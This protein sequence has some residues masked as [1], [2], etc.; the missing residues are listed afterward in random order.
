MIWNPGIGKRLKW[1]LSLALVSQRHLERQRSNVAGR[2]DVQSGRLGLA[3]PFG[4][5]WFQGFGGN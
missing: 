2:V 4:P 3:Q 5:C 1:E